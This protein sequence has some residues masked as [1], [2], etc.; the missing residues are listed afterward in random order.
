[1]NDQSKNAEYI[2]LLG[3]SLIPFHLFLYYYKLVHQHLNISFLNHVYL[4]LSNKLS[5]ANS[6]LMINFLV[7]F[8][9]LIYAITTPLGKDKEVKKSRV[10][11]KTALG[12]ILIFTS[13]V[14]FYVLPYNQMGFYVYTSGLCIGYY[15]YISN[16]AIMLQVVQMKNTEVFN[17]VK[18][19][20]PQMNEKVETEHSI[21]IP[22]H[23]FFDGKWQQGWLNF[24]NPFRAILIAG[25]PGSGKSFGTIKGWNHHLGQI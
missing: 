6:S 20:F 5:F 9:L 14:V 4:E 25:S 15:L 10:I 8:I 3:I 2:K 16:I 1:M 7:M 23:F 11:N 24:V 19:T 13:A 18:E 22:Y 21:N 12:F 17:F